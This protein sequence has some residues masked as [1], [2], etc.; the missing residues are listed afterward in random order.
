[1]INSIQVGIVPEWTII[2]VLLRREIMKENKFY[3]LPKLPYD[4]AAL[5]PYISEDN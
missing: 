3:S 2:P 1:L 4:Y 5:K